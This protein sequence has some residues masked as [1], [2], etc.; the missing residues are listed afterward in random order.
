MNLLTFYFFVS[1]A[2]EPLS[3]YDNL[4]V[5]HEGTVRCIHSR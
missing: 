5:I 2:I 1:L 4:I 3:L